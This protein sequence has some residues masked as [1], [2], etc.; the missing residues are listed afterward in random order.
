MKTYFMCMIVLFGITETVNIIRHHTDVVLVGAQGD[1]SRKYLWN[2]FFRLYLKYSSTNSTLRFFACGRI[3]P[4]EGQKITNEILQDRIKC[5]KNDVNCVAKRQTFIN[6]VKY[7]PVKTN[8]DFE[9]LGKELDSS[10]KDGVSTG[11]ILYLAI[12]PSAYVDTSYK[13][14]NCCYHA[15]QNSWTRLVLEKPFGS[16]QASSQK[17]ATDIY[18]YYVE[19]D[20]F[21][22]DHYLGKSVVKE[23]LPFRLANIEKLEYLLNNKHVERIEIAMKETIGVKG[24]IDFYD[25]YG[26]VRDVMQN[27]LTEL[28]ALIT[29]DLP[30]DITDQKAVEQKRL[31]L[32]GS[33]E[34]VE[35]KKILLGQYSQ[36]IY[37]AAEEKDNTSQSMKT[38]TY[39]SALLKICSSR[40]HGVP[41]VMVAGK[42][43][44]ERSSFIRVLFKNDRF[45]VSGCNKLNGSNYDNIRQI[46][47]QINPNELPSPGILIS[48]SLFKPYLPAALKELAI[49]TG[50]TGLY[51]QSINDFH[52]YIPIEDRD[53][54]TAVID[55]LYLGIKTGFVSTGRLSKLWHI[56][57]QAIEETALVEPR[58]YLEGGDQSLNFFI[59]SDKLQFIRPAIVAEDLD[60]DLKQMKYNSIPA[61]YLGHPL[62][63]IEESDLLQTLANH[64]HSL[65][66]QTIQSKQSFHLAVS[67]GKTPGKLF[68]LLSQMQLPWQYIHL[69]LVDERCVSLADEHSNFNL[70][71]SELI[72]HV[73]IPYLNI[74]PMP[75]DNLGQICNDADQS[76]QAYED[77]LNYFSKFKL[78]YV[79]L[80][81]GTDGHTASLMP[82]SDSLKEKHKFVTFTKTQNLKSKRMTMTFNLINNAQHISV[83]VTGSHKNNI[84]MELLESKNHLKYPIL[85]IKP[86]KGNMTFYLDFHAWLPKIVD[87]YS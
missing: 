66:W 20:I 85:G 56:W 34:K 60:A 55:D 39:A 83:L 15:N 41:I 37:Q 68:K 11:R 21:R 9:D 33:V 77:R 12:P 8:Q 22:V 32:L 18:K 2:S 80:G 63:V 38:P 24:R 19:E 4:K 10:K 82:N 1:L 69:W 59:A 14:Y 29:M 74:H 78:N 45:C 81:I 73:D 54:Y 64:I 79:L 67:G 23:I 47:F 42:H 16:D 70:L 52:F 50:H 57:S 58:K 26:V 75:V 27:H 72:K 6:V 76:D 5:D 48:K 7:L 31:E 71:H 28:L 84:V 25:Q 65:V 62:I 35:S 30:I 40:W 36:Y 17:M 49:S 51:G 3:Q 13:L 87:I 61:T 43:L 86:I 46:I 44:D 53:A